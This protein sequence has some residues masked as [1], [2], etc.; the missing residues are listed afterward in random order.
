ML[1]PYVLILVCWLVLI[2]YW[3]VSSFNTKRYA[4]RNLWTWRPRLLILVI[5]LFALHVPVVDNTLARE[6]SF[7]SPLWMRW[8]GVVVC[9][10]GVALAIWARVYLGRNWGMP[11]SLKQDAELVT[12]GPYEYIRNPIYT[13]F[14]LAMLGATLATFWWVVALVVMGGYFIWSSLTEEKIMLKAFPQQY[15]PYKARTWRLIPYVW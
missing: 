15:P 5:I 12:T 4:S 8:L 9:A 2:F 13:G 3:L 7:V 14:L 1:A 6:V 10:L 11:M